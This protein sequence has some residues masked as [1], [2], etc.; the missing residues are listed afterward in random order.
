MRPWRG[1]A[2][3]RL[4][5]GVDS[6]AVDYGLLSAAGRLISNPVHY[7]DSRT[8]GVDAGVPLD[9]LYAIT[10][11]RTMP[12]NTLFQL[13]AAG[14][15]LADADRLLLMPDL[16]SYWLTGVEGTEITN[17]STTQLLDV[18][19]QA[20]AVDLMRR[21]GVPRSLLARCAGRATRRGS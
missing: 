16:V 6:W 15:E 4:S 19:T 17:A 13:I 20:W 12:I 5:V 1:P 8:H 9:E 18:R 21:V 10:G 3:H 11:I 14:E 2:R 7:R